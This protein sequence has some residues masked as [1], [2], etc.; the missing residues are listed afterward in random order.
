MNN[1]FDL[2]IWLESDELPRTDQQ[3]A[4][5]DSRASGTSG[6]QVHLNFWKLPKCNM[7]KSI[8]LLIPHLK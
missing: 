4:N 7:E 1:R 3:E 8:Y 5:G 2:A 6:I